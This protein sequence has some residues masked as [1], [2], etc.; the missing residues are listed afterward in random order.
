VRV[1][2]LDV[3][4]FAAFLAGGLFLCALAWF[5]LFETEGGTIAGAA[6]SP[7]TGSAERPRSQLAA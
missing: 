2:R 6:G 4:I 3:W 5:L 1:N 7:S